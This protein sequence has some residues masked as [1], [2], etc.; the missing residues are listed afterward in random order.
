MSLELQT[1]ANVPIMTAGLEYPLSTGPTTF[2]PEDLM[3]VVMSQDDPAIKSPRL[4]LGHGDPRDGFSGNPAFGV[5][6][7]LRLD[8]SGTDLYGDYVGLPSWIAEILPIAYPNRS[9]EGQWDVETTTGKKWQFILTDLALLGVNWPGISNLDDLKIAWSNE[10]PEGVTVTV[11][12]G[13]EVSASAMVEAARTVQAAVNMDDVRRQFYDEIAQ[14]DQY[15]WWIK[16][17]YLDPNELIVEDDDEGKVYRVPFGIKGEDVSFDDPTEVKV[18]YVDVNKKAAASIVAQAVIASRGK[19]VAASVYT[20]RAESRAAAGKEGADVD[21]K[22]LRQGLGLA[23]DA[24]DADVATAI[25]ENNLVAEQQPGDGDGGE[26]GGEQAP[27]TQP[28]PAQPAT[29]PQP[30]APAE[31]GDGGEGG[32]TTTAPAPEQVAAQ[33]VTVD[34]QAW[35][36]TRN[37][38]LAGQ[39]AAVRQAQEDRDRHL[40]TAVA[41]GKIPPA[42]KAAWAK[43]WDSDPSGTK[44]EIDKLEPG[45]IPVTER[46]A[47][48]G[49]E[50][51]ADTG[52]PAN[53]F[54]EVAAENKGT[55]AAQSV[56]ERYKAG[57]VIMERG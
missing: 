28:A 32:Q 14:G 54:P 40:D 1:I 8:S 34:R 20:D 55:D 6:K 35:E 23:E 27:A 48:A 39:A 50:G 51:T 17:V 30:E 37:A 2:T 19:R 56:T 44:A 46:G 21:P 47:Q 15:W 41:A 45:L 52:Y 13:L 12:E 9:I 24:T 57:T 10:G 16:A 11:S 43:L 36:E 53:W 22:L 18:N 7:N 5:L 29:P 26:G 25:R 49:T 4:K 38:A 33:S 3:S 31:G 42:R